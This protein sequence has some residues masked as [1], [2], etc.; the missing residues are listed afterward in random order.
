MSNHSIRGRA[1]LQY[2]PSDMD[3]I[4]QR[5]QSATI[6]SNNNPNYPQQLH[7]I[8][9]LHTYTN[10]NALHINQHV[11]AKN[12][13]LQ[14]YQG[15]TKTHN[16]FCQ[17]TSQNNNTKNNISHKNQQHN[18]TQ[19]NFQH[20][21]Q[22][23]SPRNNFTQKFQHKN[24][25]PK[26]A[27]IIYR[28]NIPS[29]NTYATSVH[30]NNNNDIPHRRQTHCYSAKTARTPLEN[31]TIATAASNLPKGNVLQQKNT[32]HYVSNNTSDKC[33]NLTCAKSE[34]SVRF[35]DF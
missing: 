15:R 27:Q 35:F 34:K 13:N 32:A 7:K 3:D 33:H 23:I 5:F 22:Q 6:N 20:T 11:T 2:N 31:H 8:P 12:K 9:I 26:Q 21:H 16:N 1:R 4:T 29:K 18:N 17:N 30:K 19:N 28:G 25:F 10:N 24:N 14:K